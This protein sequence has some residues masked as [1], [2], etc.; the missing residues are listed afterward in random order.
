MELQNSSRRAKAHKPN[1]C[2]H[3][4]VH[5]VAPSAPLRR[6]MLQALGNIK[7]MCNSLVQD[8]NNMRLHITTPLL[9]LMFVL[10][11]SSHTFAA[12]SPESIQR[13]YVLVHGSTGGA[14]DWKNIDRLLSA[15]NHEVYRPTLTGLGERMHLANPDIDLTTHIN[16]VVNLILFENLEHVVL[17]GH[18]YGGMVITGVM[19]RIPERIDYVFFLDALVPDDGM[20]AQDTLNKIL[21][22][23]PGIT[24]IDGQVFMPWMNPNTYANMPFPKDTP[25]SLKTFTEPVSF[26]DDKAKSLPVTYVAYGTVEKGDDGSIIASSNRQRAK[27]RGWKYISIISD[28]NAQ[29]SHPEELVEILESIP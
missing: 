26:I 17:V 27:D 25:Q 11:A 3:G 28:H 16:D 22:Q 18:S 1:K 19:E 24:I 4:D 12:N 10:S 20:S 7:A 6:R 21:G 15:R 9:L 8:D 29:R 14:W 2:R 23:T 5:Y 13:T